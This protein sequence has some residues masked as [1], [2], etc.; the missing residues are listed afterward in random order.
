MEKRMLKFK[1]LSTSR[2]IFTGGV[3]YRA[4]KHGVATLPDDA[5]GA[6]VQAHAGV[7]MD[8]ARRLRGRCEA[9]AKAPRRQGQAWRKAPSLRRW[10]RASARRSKLPL[11]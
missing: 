5:P 7:R 4:D 8:A 6:H 2:A 3:E 1:R 11:P 9:A 10:L